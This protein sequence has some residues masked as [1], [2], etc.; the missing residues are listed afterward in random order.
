[1]K[2]SI[3][4]IN[5]NNAAGLRKTIESVVSQIFTD[6]EFIVI[7]GASTDGSL[8]V[9]TQYSDKISYWRSETDKG[10]YNAMNKG[11]ELAKGEYIQFLN[12][13]D[14]LYEATTL[15]E[16]FESDRTEEIL[17][18]DIAY[19]INEKKQIQEVYPS[20]ITMFRLYYNSICHQS[21]FHKR[22]L[23]EKQN[24]NENYQVVSDWEF[25]LK[26]VV[27]SNCSTFKINKTIVYIETKGS[28]WGDLCGIEREKVLKAYLPQRIL[29]DYSQF[30]SYINEPLFPYIQI[31]NKSPKLRKMTKRIMKIILIMS[32]NKN[33]I[34]K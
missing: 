2:L 30:Y 17:Y 23:F 12:S 20:E 5:R 9:I 25:L 31:F 18:G 11:I 16:V 24:Y 4:T 3:I 21:I 32:G 13:G 27:F 8:D 7:D 29:D 14:W 28:G 34:P 6:Y 15:I 33:S 10:I 26:A 19:F 22:T 1:M